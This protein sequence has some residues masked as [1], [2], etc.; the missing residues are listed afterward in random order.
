MAHVLSLRPHLLGNN[1]QQ[2]DYDEHGRD[3]PKVL[4]ART[5]YKI[6]GKKPNRPDRYRSDNNQPAQPRFLREKQRPSSASSR[7]T[8][9]PAVEYQIPMVPDKRRR[10]G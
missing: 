4:R 7:E 8:H 2:S 6:L 10:D 9:A 1:K 5:F 3:D